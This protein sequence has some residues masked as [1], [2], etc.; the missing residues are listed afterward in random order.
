MTDQHDP[1]DLLAAYALDAVDPEEAAALEAHLEGCAR[2]RRQ[3]AGYREVTSLLAYGGGEAPLALWDRIAAR[4]Q[5]E[6]APPEG[7]ERI[8]R[9]LRSDAAA[10]PADTTGGAAGIAQDPDG[11][12]STPVVALRPSRRRAPAWRVGAAVLAAAAVAAIAVLGIRVGEL[13]GRHSAPTAAATMADVR[14]A[15]AK[16]GHRA[17]TLRGHGARLNVV[18]LPSGV[19]YLYDARL[20]PLPST[21]TYQLWGVVG[22]EAISYGLLGPDP[23]VERFRA[24]AGVKA[25]AV[26]D[27][28]ASGVVVSHQTFAVSG[29]VPTL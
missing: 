11:V 19:G 2:C 20:R 23:H 29:S 8:R 18:L 14:A 27:E 28:V 17:V 10:D 25:L 9:S 24:G 6:P 1:H 21:R 7:F 12:S 26:T 16:P 4:M 13:S 5:D 22:G 3:L 15:L